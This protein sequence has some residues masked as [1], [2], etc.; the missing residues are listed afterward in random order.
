MALRDQL[1]SKKFSALIVGVIVTLGARYGLRLDPLTVG[2]IVSLFIAY[3]G[4]QG[5]ADKGKE[6]AKIEKQ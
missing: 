6:A 1:K 4:A 5:L 3:I 2:Y